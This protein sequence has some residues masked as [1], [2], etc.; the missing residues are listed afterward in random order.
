MCKESGL[1]DYW[2]KLELR[3]N[4]NNIDYDIQDNDHVTF[5]SVAITLAQ[6]FDL[7]IIYIRSIIISIC[8]LIIELLIIFLKYYFDTI[9]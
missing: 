3:R 4:N 7:F 9:N 8:V 1:Y 5:I 2:T 6:L